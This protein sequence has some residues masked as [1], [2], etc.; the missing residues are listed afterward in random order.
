[1]EV[2]AYPNVKFEEMIEVWSELTSVPCNIRQQLEIEATYSRYLKRQDSEVKAFLKDESLLLPDD[3]DYTKIHGFS[4]EVKT[5]LSG[6][7]PATLGA[8]ARIS[9]VTPAA[10]TTLLAYVKRGNVRRLS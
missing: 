10:L 2:L 6:A 4:N 1:M 5:K 7:R 3:I 8:A 9:G